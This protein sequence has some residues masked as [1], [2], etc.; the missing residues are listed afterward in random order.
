MFER[1][2]CWAM[3]N[4]SRLL[5][6]LAVIMPL[7]LLVETLSLIGGFGPQNDL[8]PDWSRIVTQL[9]SAFSVTV[10]PLFGALL[11]NRFDRYLAL[12]DHDPTSS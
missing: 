10:M 4:G 12:R 3:R 1:L 2:F 6:A 5:F 7:L 11:I 9:L 8:H